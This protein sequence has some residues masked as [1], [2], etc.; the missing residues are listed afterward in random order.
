MAT[1]LTSPDHVTGLA[2]SGSLAAI[3][4]RQALADV[5]A[6]LSRHD[7]IGLLI[8]VTG[9]EDLAPELV[10]EEPGARIAAPWDPKHC[11]RLAIVTDKVWIRAMAHFI[12][13]LAQVG[14]R[15]F[16]PSE[17]EGAMSG[18]ART[19]DCIETDHLGPRALA[20]VAR[21]G[22][23]TGAGVPQENDAGHG[24]SIS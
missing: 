22:R 12:S 7:R 20:E 18:A 8:D 14:V 21:E 1:V 17:Q 6:K 9:F 16:D 10:P 5:E 19:P 15:T 23:L 2:V 24:I 4:F 3:D 13:P 11:A